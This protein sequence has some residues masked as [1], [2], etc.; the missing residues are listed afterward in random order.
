MPTKEQMT[1][2]F[3]SQVSESIKLVFDLTSRIDERV[4]TLVERIDDVEERIDK[5]IDV[6][7]TL[8]HRVTVL[9]T[10]DSDGE[11]TD[12]KQEIEELKS[13]IQTL[14]M[15]CETLQIKDQGHEWRWLV[16]F[17]FVFRLSFVVAG[18]WLLWR[19]G[20]QAPPTP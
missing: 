10:N 3:Y 2:Q 5:F 18:G 19:L 16:A 12:L 20:W 13:K 15:K 4:K 1:E 6:Q 17:E 7:Q 11:I 14:E 8:A 9:E